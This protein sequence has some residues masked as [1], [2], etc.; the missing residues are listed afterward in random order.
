MLMTYVSKLSADEQLFVDTML[1]QEPQI[2][3][4]RR[5]Q[6]LLR[7]EKGDALPAV[8]TPTDDTPLKSFA[9]TLRRDQDAIQAALDLPWTTS[10]VEGQINRIKMINRTMYGQSGFDLLRA[11]VLHVA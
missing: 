9:A 3:V 11:R 7:H 10:L 2:A 8:L 5:L 6:R 1:T 4:A